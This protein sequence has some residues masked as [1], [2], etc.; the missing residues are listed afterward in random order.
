MV[1]YQLWV[2]RWLPLGGQR[3]QP[4]QRGAL[5]C[6]AS[7]AESHLGVTAHTLEC[8]AYCGELW[9]MRGT[10]DAMKQQAQDLRLRLDEAAHR[11]DLRDPAWALSD[12]QG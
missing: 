8:V 12:T 9:R 6:I 3:W 1:A 11:M 10:D 2:R 5:P 4:R 7:T